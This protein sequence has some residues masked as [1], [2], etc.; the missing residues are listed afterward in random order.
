[1]SLAR[2]LCYSARKFKSDE[3]LNCGLISKLF[4]DKDRSVNIKSYIY[5]KVICIY[6]NYKS[7]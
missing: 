5:I 4:D 3:A 7:Y 6:N 2:E 1:M